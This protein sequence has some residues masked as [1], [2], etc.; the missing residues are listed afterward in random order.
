M[1]TFWIATTNPH[2]IKEIK[3]F[4]KNQTSLSFKN[5]KD[6]KGYTPPEETGSS[7]KENA[8][9]KSLQLL[10]FLN[11]KNIPLNK[12]IWIL[13]EDSGLEVESLN[14]A[15][16]IFSARYGGQQTTDQKNNQLLLHNLKDKKSRLAQ[17]VCA[18]SCLSPNGT[19]LAFQG[20]CK[21]SIGFKEKGGNGFGYDPLFIPEGEIHTLGELAP[22]FKEKI[23]HRIQAIKKLKKALSL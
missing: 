3:S 2:K 11:H 1:I 21:G 10:T 23:S 18:I 14:K 22:E 6:L 5:L 7:F 20:L 4:F 9:I 8:E 17:Y 15:P 16:G 12:N 19:K 13:G